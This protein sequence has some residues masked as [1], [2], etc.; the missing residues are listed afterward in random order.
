MN[1]DKL[2]VAETEKMLAFCE[3]NDRLIKGAKYFQWVLDVYHENC[4]LKH[5][6]VNLKEQIEEL[7]DYITDHQI[8]DSEEH[9]SSYYGTRF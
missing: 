9:L 8:S 4:D 5:E 3:D 2:M 6:I 7:D 1:L